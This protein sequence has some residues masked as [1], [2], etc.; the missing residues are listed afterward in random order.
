MKR[1]VYQYMY[2]F[3]TRNLK[4]YVVKTMKQTCFNSQHYK[5]SEHLSS[6]L[7]YKTPPPIADMTDTNELL[8]N[9]Q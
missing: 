5:L 7:R 8:Y 6:Y 4:T 3:L 9:F 1:T 2:M